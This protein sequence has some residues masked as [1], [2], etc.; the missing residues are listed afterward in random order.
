LPSLRKWSDK[1]SSPVIFLRRPG[2]DTGALMARRLTC[3][4]CTTGGDMACSPI[5]L[6]CVR[7]IARGEKRGLI[8]GSP[9]IDL[10]TVPR[11]FELLCARSPRLLVGFVIEELS[12]RIRARGGEEAIMKW[13]TNKNK[14]HHNDKCK[15]ILYRCRQWRAVVDRRLQVARMVKLCCCVCRA[16]WRLATGKRQKA[17][18]KEGIVA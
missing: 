6:L 13:A 15:S 1:D 3:S 11:D 18:G 17:K 7:L 16:N 5:L 10:C 4:C 14:S 12:A 2:A 8:T 9:E